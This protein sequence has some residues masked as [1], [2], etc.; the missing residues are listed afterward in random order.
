MS[1]LRSMSVPVPDI[2]AVETA[3]VEMTHAFRE[4]HALASL[5]G[6]SGIR[7]SLRGSCESVVCTSGIGP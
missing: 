1:L 5:T 2:P 6:I 7:L 3:I 4:K